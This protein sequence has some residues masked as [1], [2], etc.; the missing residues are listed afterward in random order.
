LLSKPVRTKHNT[1]LRQFAAACPF[2]KQGNLGQGVEKPSRVFEKKNERTGFLDASRQ[3][4]RSIARAQEGSLSGT[5]RIE[6]A[7]SGMPG[8]S[9]YRGQ[10]L[11][12]LGVAVKVAQDQLGH[13]NPTMT[14]A[15]YTHALPEAQK[16]AVSQLAAQ[17][18]PDVPKFVPNAQNGRQQPL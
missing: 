6:I 16:A 14:L 13:S 7:E 9:P 4:D 8:V 15:I 5:G 11:Q 3:T 12:H 17:L 2:Q 1:G 18:F 10:L